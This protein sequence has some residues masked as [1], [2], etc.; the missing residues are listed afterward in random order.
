MQK[1]IKYLK[2]FLNIVTLLTSISLL[3]F[4]PIISFTLVVFFPFSLIFP[5]AS[6]LVYHFFLNGDYLWD[7]I[8]WEGVGKPPPSAFLYYKM[9][10]SPIKSFDGT[11]KSI[12]RMSLALWVSLVVRIIVIHLVGMRVILSFPLYS[13]ISPYEMWKRGCKD[14]F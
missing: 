7:R 12:I 4:P 9:C 5:Y 1:F 11:I 3:G 8:W 10:Y 2:L 14:R 13:L 6:C